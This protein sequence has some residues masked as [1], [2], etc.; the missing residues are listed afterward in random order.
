MDLDILI[1]CGLIIH[2]LLTNSLKHAFKETGDPKIEVGFS[3]NPDNQRI[4]L[5]VWDNGCGLPEEISP[6]SSESL[7]LRLVSLLTLQLRGTLEFQREGGTRATISFP[8]E[9][10]R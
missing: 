7:G 6:E 10:T 4:E 3:M 2:E 5:Y 8:F 1:P 9:Q